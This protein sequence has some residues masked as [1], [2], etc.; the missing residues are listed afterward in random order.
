MQTWARRVNYLDRS[1]RA[2]TENRVNEILDRVPAGRPFFLWISFNDPHHVWDRNA[3]PQP[4]DPAKA[5]APGFL[6]DLP[7][8]RDDLG[9]YYDEVSRMDGEFQ[10]VLDILARRGA[11]ENTLVAFMGDNGFGFPH[12]KGSLYDP[13]LNVPLMM[14]WPAR[15]RAGSATSDLVS[16]EDLA[17][18][19][20]E[21][22][23]LATP[24]EM[25]GQSFLPVP[26]RQDYKA[27]DRIFAA[28]LTHGS[29]T[30]TPA[31]RADTFDQ[32]RCVRSARYKLIY[33]CTPHQE[34][35]P[36]DSGRD[37]GWQ[38]MIAAHGAGKL[39]QRFERTYFTR[40]RPVVELYDLERDPDEMENL[41]GRS[42][43]GA[44]ERELKIALQ[45][46]M[47]VDY[48]FL[49]LPLAE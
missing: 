29:S 46:K 41:A 8:L 32:S 23:G 44:V 48:D 11:A 7:G 24:R 34:Y 21:A 6:P 20:L 13:G 43:V 33:N 45:E 18:T 10:S 19:M 4:H 17:P 1:A 31:T 16:G 40:P 36:V 25:T 38:E 5:P 26:T 39:A 22:A 37:A 27:R 30:Y 42:E 12:G 35:W 2:Q 9:R 47:M 49:P 28:R 15:V 3:I 14:R